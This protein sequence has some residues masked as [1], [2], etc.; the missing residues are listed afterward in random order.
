MPGDGAA[1]PD[2]QQIEPVPVYPL[3]WHQWLLAHVFLLNQSSL[4][5]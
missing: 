1:S 5:F 4:V 2:G 3:T